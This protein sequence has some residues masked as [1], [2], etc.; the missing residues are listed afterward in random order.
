MVLVLL[1]SDSFCI[2]FSWISICFDALAW[3]T[4]SMFSFCFSRSKGAGFPW[5]PLRRPLM[6]VWRSLSERLN[7][8][9]RDSMDWEPMFQPAPSRYCSSESLGSSAWR[10]AEKEAV[11]DKNSVS[12]FLE[13][14][15]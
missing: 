3:R 10:E 4:V 7:W 8:W 15:R 1:V 9:L 5:A 11:S 13:F 12:N 6:M 14:I 2:C